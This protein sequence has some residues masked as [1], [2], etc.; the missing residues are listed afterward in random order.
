MYGYNLSFFKVIL[1]TKYLSPL[2][3]L[4]HSK[5]ATTL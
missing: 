5:N 4:S 1:L 2:K 3:P